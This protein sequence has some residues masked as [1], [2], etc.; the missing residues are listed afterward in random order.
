MS[1]NTKND[2]LEIENSNYKSFHK[3]NAEKLFETHGFPSLKH[4]NWLYWVPDN[5]QD[6]LLNP[7]RQTYKKLNEDADIS[8]V[9]GSLTFVS[10]KLSQLNIE[11]TSDL[12]LL[13]DL[14]L[15]VSSS[16]IS[17]ILCIR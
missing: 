5:F 3:Q 6:A 8:I 12:K 15:N 11:E 2:T 17:S 9:N 13:E 16:P 1:Q 7:C 14:D 4:E 10:S